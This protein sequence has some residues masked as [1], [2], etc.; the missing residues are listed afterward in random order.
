MLFA[1][2]LTAVDIRWEYMV[3]YLFHL[4]F[5]RMWNISISLNQHM[6]CV[7]EVWSGHAVAVQ[8]RLGG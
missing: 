1:F 4:P 6:L 5:L 8:S 3:G 2:P 7:T